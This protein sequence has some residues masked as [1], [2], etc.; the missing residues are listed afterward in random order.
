MTITPS[1]LDYPVL[2]FLHYTDDGEYA[3]VVEVLNEQELL[4]LKAE[5]SFYQHIFSKKFGILNQ[6]ESLTPL[7]VQSAQD[8]IKGQ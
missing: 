4:M 1:D 8:F 2:M 5:N 7:K 6:S 3:H